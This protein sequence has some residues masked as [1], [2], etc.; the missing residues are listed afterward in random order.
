MEARKLMQFCGHAELVFIETGLH[1]GQKG[2]WFGTRDRKRVFYNEDQ[3]HQILERRSRSLF[4]E[5]VVKA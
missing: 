3:V 1:E 4:N 5:P 2:L